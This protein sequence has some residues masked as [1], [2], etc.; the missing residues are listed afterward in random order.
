MPEKIK[1]LVIEDNS[2]DVRL[3]KI[4]LEEYF[5]DKFEF[6]SFAYLQKG[7]DALSSSPF[8]IIILD[9]TLPDSAGLE[10][11]KKVHEHSPAIPIIV[12]TGI[13][14]ELI[15]INAM[16]LG[17]Q[18]FLVKG[19]IHSKELS[20]S[21]NYSIERFKLLKEL[22]DNTKDLEKKTLDLLKE[23]I[24]LS[25]AQHLSHIGSWDW[26]IEK[27][28]VIWSEELYRIYNL[29][30]QKNNISTDKIIKIVHPAD[31]ENAKRMM[32]EAKIKHEPFSFYY[33]II[34]SDEIIKT[35]QVRG[36]VIVND[37]GQAI[38][39]S[40]TAQDVTDQIHKEELEKLVLATTQSYNSVVIFDRN[41]KVEWV[42]EGFT[43]LTGYTLN[44]F[45]NKSIEIL[46]GNDSKSAAQQKN[47]MNS[48]L[49]IK[50]PFT[51]ETVNYTKEGDKYWALTTI[52]PILGNDGEAERFITIESDISLRKKIEEEL[53]EAN[54]ITEQSLAKVNKTLDELTMAKKELEV[55][56]KVKGQFMAN[57]SHE[58]RTPMNA[59]IGFTDLLLKTPL[60]PEQKQYVDAVKISGKNLLTIINDILDFSKIESGKLELE[61]IKF[62][63][64]SVVLTVTELMLPKSNE[65]N[66][67]LSS[68]IDPNIPDNLIGDPT[69][70]NQILLN[71]VGNA[72]KFTNQG[73]IK[74]VIELQ[75]GSDETVDLK[76]SIIDTGIGIP[77]DKLPALFKEFN[78][79]SNETTRKYGGTG[80][81]LA[82]VK[83]LVELMKGTVSVQSE[84]N[85]GS[86]FTFSIPLKRNTGSESENKKTEEYYE[87]GDLEGVRVLLVED[88]ILNQMLAKKVLTDWKLK[89]EVAENGLIGIEK[90][91]QM[92]FDVI[93][94]DI[95]MPEMDGYTATLTIRK[96]SSP[97]S[98]TPI[99]AMT[100]HALSGE[101]EKCIKAGM[102]DYISKPFEQ[103]MLYS[104][105]Y[106]VLKKHTIKQINS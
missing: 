59:V 106:S 70:L 43:K 105:I 104:K 51:Y 5:E 10:T 83:Q 95:Q 38:K 84:V 92:D 100:A 71:L 72:I 102:N 36:K 56:M 49:T 58:I 1:I 18:D 93:L 88:N 40:G 16:K 80:L 7:L 27:N 32:A 24:K 87:T 52:T 13:D 76:F 2:A 60:N 101:A 96:L 55:S 90:L 67:R 79:V 103:K 86:E 37:A 23:Q 3:I 47:I 39:M 34:V 20:R 73:E 44:D 85:K 81:G 75:S 65:K 94:M 9:L 57:M 26:D 69:R 54:K 14:N 50:K 48:L 17:A 99:I 62:N 15:G 42:N 82:I 41:Q 30:P 35:I 12:L 68:K 29:D 78:Q 19:N 89:V 4:Y 66:I 25:E 77:K 45:K 97:K 6:S 91:K 31:K 61:Q 98:N 22:S 33:R 74:I 63:L 11:F 8:D 28:I 53:L 64:S 21:V 46:S